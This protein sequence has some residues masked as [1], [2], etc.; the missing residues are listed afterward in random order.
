ML[1]VEKLGWDAN[2]VGERDHRL[3][4]VPSIKLRSARLGRNGDAVYCV[5]LRIRRPNAD[6][7]LSNTQLHSLEHF[8]LEGLHRQ[9]PANF[10]S[11]GIMGCQTGYY[12]V[13]L[14][15]GRAAKICSVL[16]NILTDMQSATAVP[17]AR[18][19]QCGNYKNHSLELSQQVAREVLAA[20]STWLKVT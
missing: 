10:V 2:T 20:R 5:D 17:Y 14:N 12:L 16:E 7:Y 19:E 11:V 9:L 4:K 3:L 15:E 18:I 6:E 8:L 13:F 1:D